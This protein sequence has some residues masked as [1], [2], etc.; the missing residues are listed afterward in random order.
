M[1]FRE[2]CLSDV[3]VCSMFRTPSLFFKSRSMWYN[4]ALQSLTCSVAFSWTLF[5][6]WCASSII[7]IS[8]RSSLSTWS[9]HWNVHHQ[10]SSNQLQFGVTKSIPSRF[11]RSPTHLSGIGSALS[12]IWDIV[13]RILGMQDW[14]LSIS[15][16]TAFRSLN[17][18]VLLNSMSSSLWDKSCST[19][20]LF[21]SV[22]SFTLSLT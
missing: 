20:F 2:W 9:W 14:R 21:F 7:L 22:S 19:S 11:S 4:E 16:Q 1:R 15:R 18:S 12:L 3:L 13:F 10:K 6:R 5:I 17:S 8:F